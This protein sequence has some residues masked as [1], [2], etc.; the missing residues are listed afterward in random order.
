MQAVDGREEGRP[1]GREARAE[2]GPVQPLTFDTVALETSRSHLSGCRLLALREARHGA[3]PELQGQEGAQ[4]HQEARAY[5]LLLLLAG[6]VVCR[7]R[8]K[9]TRFSPPC[10]LGTLSCPEHS[11]PSPLSVFRRPLPPRHFSNPSSSTPIPPTDVTNIFGRAL[12][13][14]TLLRSSVSLLLCFGTW[15]LARVRQQRADLRPL[16]APLQE[17]Q[18]R[19]AHQRHPGV[20][21]RRPLER[22][23]SSSLSLPRPPTHPYPPRLSMNRMRCRNCRPEPS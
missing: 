10:L 13:L 16:P 22:E 19:G 21:P 2:V 12:Q 8:Q 7:A 11:S 6:V 1:R 3:P 23:R 9:L 4:A 14:G 5:R 20:A 18:A 15:G 17:A